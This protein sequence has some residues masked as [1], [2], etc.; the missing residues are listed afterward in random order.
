MLIIPIEKN[1]LE[2]LFLIVHLKI[3]QFIKLNS[4]NNS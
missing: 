4:L 3:F 1:T 2:N